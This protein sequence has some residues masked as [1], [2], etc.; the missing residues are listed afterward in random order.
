MKED[1]TLSDLAKRIQQKWPKWSINADDQ[2]DS[3]VAFGFYPIATEV[4]AN[5]FR[6]ALRLWEQ[7]WDHEIRSE[8]YSM[9]ILIL[10]SATRDEAGICTLTDRDVLLINAIDNVFTLMTTPPPQS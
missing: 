8:H 6:N 10:T 2:D 9:G 1:Q 7:I 4:E 5:L 3:E